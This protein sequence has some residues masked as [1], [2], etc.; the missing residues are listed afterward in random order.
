MAKKPTTKDVKPDMQSGMDP[1]PA[2]KPKKAVDKQLK[3]ADD[4]GAPEVSDEAKEA[5]LGRQVRGW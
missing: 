5:E 3:D 1:T 2:A 4:A